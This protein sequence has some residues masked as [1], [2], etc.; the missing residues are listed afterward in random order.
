MRNAPTYLATRRAGGGAFVLSSQ[1]LG[2][3]SSATR[4]RAAPSK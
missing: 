2:W 4:L 3:S 1:L